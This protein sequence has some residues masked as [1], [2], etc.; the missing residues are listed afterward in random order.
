MAAHVPDENEEWMQLEMSRL[1]QFTRIFPAGDPRFKSKG[2][3]SE[4]IDRD[5][6]NDN[7]RYYSLVAGLKI[8]CTY[9]NNVQFTNIF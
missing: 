1:S 6:D 7:G 3:A 2:Q 8:A 9:H 4:D 5:E